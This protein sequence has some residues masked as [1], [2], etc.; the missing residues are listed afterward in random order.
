MPRFVEREFRA[1]LDCGILAHGFVRVHC[2]DCGHDRLVAFSCK[3]RGFCPSCGGRRMA[4]TAARLVD[5]VLPA[6]PVR[7]WVLTL[8]F[9]LRYRL[10]FDAELTGALLSI[11]VRALF[12]SLRRRA[13]QRQHLRFPQC[14]A[15]TFIQRFGDAL[16]LN[17]HFHTIA[18]D[19]VYD[20]D[21]RHRAR[22]LV[23]PPPATAD[24]EW[25][26]RRVARDLAR[27]LVRRG[28]GPDAD[29]TLA[30]PLQREDPLLTALY[31]ASVLGR[32]A[33]GG[34]A[35]QRVLA[36]G[37]GWMPRISKRSRARAA[38]RWRACPSTPSWRCRPG[39]ADASSG[40]AAMW[41]GR[42][43]RGSDCRAF[44]TGGCSTAS[45]VA[46][47]TGP[48]TSLSNRW[49]SW[50]S[51][52]PWCPR[53]GFT[54][55]ATTASSG[56]PP[57]I[58]GS[59]YPVRGGRAPGIPSHPTFHPP[60]GKAPAPPRPIPAPAPRPNAHPPIPGAQIRHPRRRLRHRPSGLA[61][62]SP[63][64]LPDRSAGHPRIHCL[65]RS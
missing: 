16:N 24:V 50:R 22:F 58:A 5:S 27:L 26:A 32:I 46:G 37:T 64:P 6:V 56:R 55:S 20:G 47:A 61:L 1:F 7:Q 15:V 62:T 38:S 21:P 34:R 54:K 17:V 49:S 13:R 9:G 30:D 48:P 65:G 10:A 12:A 53:R 36:S 8:P 14:G 63:A 28:L 23:L 52:P 41:E 42:R 3:G 25:V 19:G 51:W 11:F 31:G 39:I 35:G 44:P 18:L 29:P 45:S 33:T 2:D 43:W 57:A 59:S 4:D 60:Q 40:C